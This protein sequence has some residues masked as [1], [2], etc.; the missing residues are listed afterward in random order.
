MIASSL[1]G[2]LGIAVDDNENVYIADTSNNRVLKETPSAGGYS[3]SILSFR[4]PVG[5]A[6][7]GNGNLYVSGEYYDS[8]QELDLT[9]PPSLDFAST[10]YG[11]TSSDS[12]KTVTVMN[13]GNTALTCVH[14]S[15][16]LDATCQ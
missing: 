16:L 5:V 15:R 12:P 13:S 6:I 9:D 1:S 8:V 4:F 11:L 3:Q 14:R 2:P 7:A 10:V